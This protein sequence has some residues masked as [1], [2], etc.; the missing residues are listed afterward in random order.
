MLRTQKR[1][2]GATRVAA[3]IDWVTNKSTLLLVSFCEGTS[4]VIEHQGPKGKLWNRLLLP[5][6]NHILFFT[7]SNNSCRSGFKLHNMFWRYLPYYL[8]EIEHRN[9]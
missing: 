8:F 4:D 1:L 9:I 7:C 5:D 6:A 3:S 2:H